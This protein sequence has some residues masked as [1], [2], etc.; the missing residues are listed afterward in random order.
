MRLVNNKVKAVAMIT[1]AALC[2]SGCGS[3]KKDK[4]EDTASTEEVTTTED[5]AAEETDR[6]T[7]YQVSL[8]QGK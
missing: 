4:K 5:T 1:A 3:K 7:V 8:L 2:I 6:E